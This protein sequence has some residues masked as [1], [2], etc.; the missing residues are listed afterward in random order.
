MLQHCCDDACSC[1]NVHCCIF[2]LVICLIV[3]LYHT[4][5]CDMCYILL[6]W[7]AASEASSIQRHTVCAQSIVR[8]E[9]LQPAAAA[10]AQLVHFTHTAWVLLCLCFG[11]MCILRH[12]KQQLKH[13]QRASSIQQ[14]GATL[15]VL[16]RS[17][18]PETTQPSVAA[19][20]A[21]LE[22]GLLTIIT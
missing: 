10:E 22:H 18:Y 17:V 8:V 13:N 19:Q 14:L 12:H 21:R 9:K 15:P 1:L 20:L 4:Y 11:V 5:L 2:R 6:M 16:G 7:P 3:L